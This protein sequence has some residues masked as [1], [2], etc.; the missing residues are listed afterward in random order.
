M[1]E[2]AELRNALERLQSAMDD[3]IVRGVRSAGAADLARL[4][5]LRDEF[6]SAG[7]EH[8]AG[9]L[10]ILIDAIQSGARSAAAE[11]LRAMTA[12]RLFE[13]MLTVEVAASVLAAP[14]GEE[15]ED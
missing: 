2:I 8:L 9:R 10:T 13:R 1:D 11:L 12:L 15:E 14:S 4:S 5:A 3:L 6:R 7:A